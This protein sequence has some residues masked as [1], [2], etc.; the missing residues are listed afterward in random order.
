M[1]IVITM[2]VLDDWEASALVCAAIDMA[3]KEFL[4]ETV[5]I[6][7]IDDG[8]SSPITSEFSGF[9]PQHLDWVSTLTLRRN[10]GHQRAIAIGLTYIHEHVPCDAVVVMDADGEDRAEDICR[11]VHRLREAATPT[12][13]FAERGRRMEGALFKVFYQLYRLMHYILTGRGIRMGNFSALPAHHLNA[14][15]ACPELW[16]HYAAAVIKCRLKYTTIPVDRAQRLR[17]KSHM[18]FVGLVVHGFSALFTFHEIVSTRLLIASAGSAAVF[19]LLLSVVVLMKTMTDLA[20]PGWASMV[21]GLLFLLIF[22][23]V[24]T[25]ITVIFS[26]M[27]SRNALGFLPL[28]DYS[29]F[30]AGCERIYSR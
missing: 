22:Q 21:S 10:V 27:I 4:A 17:G 8:S 25:S 12:A 13:V 15:I 24:A 14:L 26:A 23:S 7:L 29:Y 19:F 18:N 30:V 2:P 28:R 11:L 9:R 3:A 16:N 20:I 1:R 6:L 5:G